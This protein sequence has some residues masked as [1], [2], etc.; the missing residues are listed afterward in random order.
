MT[1]NYWP[2]F[3]NIHDLTNPGGYCNTMSASI[4]LFLF[5]SMVYFVS[6]APG[7]P[8]E[9]LPVPITHKHCMCALQTSCRCGETVHIRTLSCRKQTLR[10][11]FECCR[12]EHKDFYNA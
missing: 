9:R 2:V 11:L 10:S 3:T 6:I 5:Y 4:L 1:H 7:T 12:I 8:L